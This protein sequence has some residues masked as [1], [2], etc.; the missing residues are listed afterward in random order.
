MKNQLFALSTYFRNNIQ[1]WLLPNVCTLCGQ[2]GQGHLALCADCHKELKFIGNACIQCSLPIE[3]TYT[4]IV[5]GRCMQEP[6][7]Y[8]RTLCLFVYE[9]PARQLI[10]ALKFHKKLAHARLLGT[11]LGLALKQREIAR[12][13][14]IL[15]VP[16]SRKRLRERGFNQSLE[17]AR[18]VSRA[19]G[20]PIQHHLL[21][22]VRD[23]PPQSQLKLKERHKNIRLAFQAGQY[24]IPDHVAIIDDV[25]TSGSTC[26]EVARTLKQAGA[27]RVDVW[28]VAR[29]IK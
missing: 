12:P 9:T 23:T 6:P 29:A 14:A 24:S 26:H 28:C 2:A 11:L 25:M 8:D 7:A 16:L 1:N 5:C 19:L 13:D 3:D 21:E 10:Q 18:P 27:K 20:I 15:P 4:S 17:L 22:R